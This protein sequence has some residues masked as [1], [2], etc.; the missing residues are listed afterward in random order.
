MEAGFIAN[1]SRVSMGEVALLGAEEDVAKTTDLRELRADAVKL[2]FLAEFL[3]LLV[4]LGHKVLV[5]FMSES[6]PV[7]LPVLRPC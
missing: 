5:F 7:P 2:A 3:P 6:K 4:R 1:Q